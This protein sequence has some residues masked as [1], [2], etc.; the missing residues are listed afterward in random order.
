MMFA[1]MGDIE[2]II[3][4]SMEEEKKEEQKE[5]YEV[6]EKLPSLKDLGMTMEDVER[7]KNQYKK[8][9]IVN[10]LLHEIVEADGKVEFIPVPAAFMEKPE[11]WSEEDDEA[12]SIVATCIN[13]IINYNL[14]NA[15]NQRYVPLL[16]AE[17]NESG[18]D[19][20]VIKRFLKW[21]ILGKERLE[22]QDESGNIKARS[23]FYLTP[24]GL[25]FLEAKKNQLN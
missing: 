24:Y 8:Y 2:D 3:G 1:S 21:N 18:M 13:Q 16:K 7:V 9:A 22:F 23:V 10:C 19:T 6:Q 20:R 5:M 14:N 4:E 25:G 12:L 17:L 15:N 11:G